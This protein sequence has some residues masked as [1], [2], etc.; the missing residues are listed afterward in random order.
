MKTL[1]LCSSLLLIGLLAVTFAK[2]DI[3]P[4][5]IAGVW[6]FDEGKGDDAEDSS[7]NGFDGVVEGDAAWVDGK[8]GKALEF[9]GGEYVELTNSAAG[10][11]FGGTEPFSVTAWVSN[12]GG[13]TIIGKF[14]G[15][16][17]GAY[18]V[19]INAGGV[20][21][22]HREVAPWSLAGAAAIQAGDFGHIAATYDGEVMRIYID[23]ELDVE[24]DRGAQ[25]TDQATPVLIG[26]RFTNGAPSD[27][28][29]GI[30]DEVALF[31]V[32]LT[33]DQIE[34]V[35]RGLSG[36]QAVSASGKLI[37]TWG[38]IKY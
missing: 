25:N 8:S 34:D 1:I 32:A 12:Q 2:A 26:A 36:L 17:I 38:K 14:N 21:G 33:E 5:L 18:I 22:F 11:P 9:K 10:L 28:F 31:N 20:V 6:F 3:D 37:A 15:G 13:G 4:D 16:I 35:M 29:R 23:G 27:F 24:Q 19:T 7:G 30:L